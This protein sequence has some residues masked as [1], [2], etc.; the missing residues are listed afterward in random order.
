MA[1]K[2][3]FD[4][5]DAFDQHVDMASQEAELLIEAIQNFKTADDLAPILER[6]HE[7][8]HQ[9]DEINKEVY[10]NVAR[11]FVTPFDR[12][13]IIQI[14]QDLDNITD[15]IESIIQ[16]FFMFDIHYMHPKAIEFAE[17]IH[18]SLKALKKSMSNFR[19]FKKLKKVQHMAEDVNLLEEQADTLYLETIR[20][21]YTEE[22]DDP[23]RV[24]VWSRLIERLEGACDACKTVADTMFTTM[25]KNS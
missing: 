15:M 4:Y 20:Q 14:T 16:R 19:E 9:A 12:A 10:V 2:V 25:L 18:K 3:K 11:D 21:L 5:F 22:N 17:I 13:D 7:I 1:K 23:V 8:E 6:A 24:Y